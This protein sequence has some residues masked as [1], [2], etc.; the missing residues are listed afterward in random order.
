MIDIL[1]FNNSSKNRFQTLKKKLGKRS[2]KINQPMKFGVKT[3]P[4]IY[5]NSSPK[6]PFKQKLKKK[7]SQKLIKQLNLRFSHEKNLEKV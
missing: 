7:K 1:V 2:Y 6:I 3:M 4:L 5:N